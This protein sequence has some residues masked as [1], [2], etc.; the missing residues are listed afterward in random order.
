MHDSLRFRLHRPIMHLADHCATTNAATLG[1]V[2]L[3]Q[4][5]ITEDTATRTVSREE[6]Q[7][8]LM[9]RFSVHDISSKQTA[10]I[11]LKLGDTVQTLKEQLVAF[12]DI[13]VA[14]QHLMFGTKALESSQTLQQA[15]IFMGSTVQLITNM[16]DVCRQCCQCR[17]LCNVDALP[18][19]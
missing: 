10:S 18:V 9:I 13:P 14:Q 16:Q 8:K 19:M 4:T 5:S 6:I 1:A 15:G 12:F 17:Q 3:A 2:P 7:D 11:R